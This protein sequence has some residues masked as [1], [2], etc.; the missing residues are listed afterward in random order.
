VIAGLLLA[1]GQGTRFGGDKLLA[2]LRGRP[3]LFWSAAALAPQVD[4]LYVVVPPNARA[5]VDAMA[6]LAHHVVENPAHGEG[7][8]SSIRTGI[9]ALPETAEAAVIALGDQ[10][11]VAADVVRRL[12]GR[13]RQGGACA[14]APRYRNGRGN[15]VLFGREA[16]GVLA[17]LEGDIGARGALDSLGCA[18]ALVAVD[19]ERPID[20]DTR[21]ILR[22]LAG[23][24]PETENG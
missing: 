20:V 15:P 24:T 10:P 6:P 7:M 1:A 17:T 2:P 21:E 8:A 13:W 19:D 3:V 11:L 23:Q 5:R 22:T 14:V 4:A 18:L 9:A 16:F 12:I